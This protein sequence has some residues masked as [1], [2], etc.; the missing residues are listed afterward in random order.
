MVSTMLAIYGHL[1]VW[2]RALSSKQLL[3]RTCHCMRGES[4]SMALLSEGVM[5]SVN[6]QSDQERLLLLTAR[7]PFGRCSWHFSVFSELVLRTFPCG[8]TPAQSHFG[9]SARPA[10]LA[11][12][13]KLVKVLHLIWANNM[14]RPWFDTMCSLFIQLFE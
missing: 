4:D 6:T 2:R 8:I 7:L 3:I 1:L 11:R 5:A 9:L 10:A 14:R 13:D 12:C